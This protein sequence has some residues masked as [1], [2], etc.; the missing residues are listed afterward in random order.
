MRSILRRPA[1]LLGSIAR[2]LEGL[3]MKLAVALL[4]ALLLLINVEVAGRY[5]LGYSTLVADEYGGYAY[6]WMVLLGVVHLLRSDR[7]LTMTAVIDRFPKLQ[8]AF[9]LIGA[10]VGLVVA[11][12]LLDS[13][14]SLVR[15]TALFGTRSIQPSASPLIIPQMILPVGYAILCL[16]YLEEIL[17]R[18]SGLPPRRSEDE[19]GTYGVGEIG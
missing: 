15:T 5:F 17:R 19:P 14:V 8:N 9:G 18:L 4:L 12:I 2:A 11:A 6:T 1:L 3:A 16:A 7:Y 13:T 10:A